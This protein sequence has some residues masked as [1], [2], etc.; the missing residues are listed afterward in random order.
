[1]SNNW[2]HQ[3]Q[4]D[5]FYGNPR[6]RNGAAS[7]TWEARNLVRLAPPFVMRF[8]GKPISAIRIHRKCADSLDRVLRAIW[9]AS[10]QQQAVIDAWGMSDYAGAYNYRLTRGGASL[11]SHSWGCAI[12]FDAARNAFG[13]PTPNFANVPEVLKAFADEGWTW[14]GNWRKKDGMH[15]QAAGV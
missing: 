12:D 8:M 4:R 11:S 2:P 5:S 7:P 13:D 10:G 3:S 15:W 6:G 9:A 14:G 1:M